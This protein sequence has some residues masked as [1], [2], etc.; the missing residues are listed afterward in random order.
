VREMRAALTPG[1]RSLQGTRTTSP[2]D[3]TNPSISKDRNNDPLT[4][5][6]RQALVLGGS[7]KVNL[8]SESRPSGQTAR[9]GGISGGCEDRIGTGPPRAKTEVIHVDLGYWAISAVQR[10][11]GAP[12]RL[13]TPLGPCF[14]GTPSCN[15]QGC[16][17]RRCEITY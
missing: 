17:I 2:H 12:L 16:I 9:F 11:G 1:M 7:A 4:R 8:R 10:S 13:P 5:V 14:P 6:D 3:P 15:C